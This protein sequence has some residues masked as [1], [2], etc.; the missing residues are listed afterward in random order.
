MK[1]ILYPLRKLHGRIH[2]FRTIAWPIIMQRIHHP[3]AVFLVLTPEHGNLGDHAI[4]Q[5][6]I[7]M[8]N[9]I[10]VEFIELTGKALLPLV[11]SRW[12][13]VMNGKPILI[14]GGGNLGTLWFEVERITRKI[15]SDNPKSPIIIFPNT[16]YYEDSTWGSEELEQSIQLY[17]KHL[18]L[19][20]YARE[21][22]SF[23]MMSKIYRNVQLVPDMV[24]SLNETRVDR[25]RKGCLLCLRNDC[26]KTR[27]TEDEA[28]IFQQATT[29]FGENVHY[30]DMCVNYSISIEQREK[31]LSQKFD[32]F[33]RASL[34]ITDRLHGMIFCAI[35][36]TPCI[37]INSKSPKV[38]GCYQWINNLDY[39]QFADHV[40][41]ISK[42]YQSIPVGDHIYSN[43]HLLPYYQKLMDDISNTAKRKTC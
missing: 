43:T 27:T 23:E 3:K 29:L 38:R 32:E 9:E 8:L 36:G 17:G 15:I 42:L 7:K 18:N 1:D 35:T 10:G 14:T 2:D 34:V 12:L 13:N 16:I 26:E 31:E 20:I 11:Y 28:A 41:D 19:H 40:S 30:T 24:L 22:F 5:A 33:R 25:H 37:V 4:A 21:H 39:I 6:E